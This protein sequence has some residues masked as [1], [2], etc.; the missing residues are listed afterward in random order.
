[1]EEK[2]IAIQ[3]EYGYD[4]PVEYLYGLVIEQQEY[5]MDAQK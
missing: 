5:I 4:V 1:M 3:S 2:Y